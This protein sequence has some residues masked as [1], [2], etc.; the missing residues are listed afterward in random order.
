[1]AVGVRI[2]QR[3]LDDLGG[4][5]ASDPALTGQGL[6]EHCRNGGTS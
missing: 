4:R 5:R 2:K 1:M 3:R 6:I